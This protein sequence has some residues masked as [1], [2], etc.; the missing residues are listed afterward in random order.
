MAETWKKLA[1]ED[2][3]IL[4]TLFDAQSVLAATADDTPAALVVAEQELVG[5]ITGGDVDGI[6]IGIA[7]NNIV[8]MDSADAADDEFARFTANGLES[9]TPAEVL[10]ALSTAAAAA[11]DW[12]GQNLTNLGSLFI[13]EKADAAA[14]VD[15]SGQIWVNTATPNEL[16]FTTDAGD[17]IQLTSGS[18]IMGP[19]HSLL[20]GTV[21]SDSVAQAVTRGSI[22]YGNSTPK[23]DELVVGTGFLNGDGTDV[24]YKSYADTLALL[25]GDAGAAFDWNGQ[26]LTNVLLQNL[27]DDAAKTALTAVV[28]MIAYQ[29]DDDAVYICTEGE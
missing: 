16:W 7:D 11:F 21:I 28:G 9:L 6:A 24:S 2:D 25:S 8:Q 17:D 14:D 13:P 22:I 26:Q 12:G 19:T 18:S 27:A 4:K 1:Y 23:W 10:A 5:R 29:V 20:D 3:V 15:A